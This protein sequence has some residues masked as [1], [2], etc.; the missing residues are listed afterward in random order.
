MHPH[1]D[2]LKS[3]STNYKMPHHLINREIQ[4]HNEHEKV[5]TSCSRTSSF[6]GCSVLQLCKTNRPGSVE[7]SSQPTCIRP[8][9]I[10]RKILDKPILIYTHGFTDPITYL[11]PKKKI[12]VTDISSKFI[13]IAQN[14][15]LVR[16]IRN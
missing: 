2:F 3:A 14:Y 16:R 15:L 8:E 11:I 10:K 5:L 4:R 7:S 9:A 13:K 1:D 12:P 6:K